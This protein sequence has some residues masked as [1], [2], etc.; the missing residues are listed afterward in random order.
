[1]SCPNESFR[2]TLTPETEDA[3]AIVD[4]SIEDAEQAA[5]STALILV[6]GYGDSGA[7]QPAVEIAIQKQ[8]PGSD[9][10]VAD[11]SSR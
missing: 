4:A 2:L 3:A 5:P 6:H 9:G 7:N 8:L 11:I 10:R 1:M